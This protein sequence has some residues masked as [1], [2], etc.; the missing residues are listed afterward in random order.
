MSTCSAVR[1][2]LDTFGVLSTRKL[3][4]FSRKG[5]EIYKS[6]INCFIEKLQEATKKTQQLMTKERLT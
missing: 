6:Y 4:P 2:T 1:S 5:G 3:A